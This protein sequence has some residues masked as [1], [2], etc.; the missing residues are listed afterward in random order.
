MRVSAVNLIQSSGTCTR[1]A[2]R[3]SDE[4]RC[5]AHRHPPGG[6]KSKRI[7]RAWQSKSCD[8][9][10]YS[11]YITTVLTVGNVGKEKLECAS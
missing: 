1:Y 4:P 5:W 8:Y 3:Y 10:N 2:R 9:I 7:A 11:F 6:E